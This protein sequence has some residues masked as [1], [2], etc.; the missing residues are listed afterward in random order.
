[1][2][3]GKDELRC[4]RIPLGWGSSGTAMAGGVRSSPLVRSFR[5]FD[6]LASLVIFTARR[7]LV[8]T[9]HLI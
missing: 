1:M 6:T 4:G 5:S 8:V 9:L 3:K 2:W 7:K